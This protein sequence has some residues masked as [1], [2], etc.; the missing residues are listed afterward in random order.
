M[1][2]FDVSSTIHNQNIFQVGRLR[3]QMAKCQQVSQ[4]RPLVLCSVSWSVGLST[5]HGTTSQLRVS[6]VQLFQRDKHVLSALQ[7]DPN[8]DYPSA[9]VSVIGRLVVNV[10]ALGGRHTMAKG[11]ALMICRLMIE[12]AQLS[13]SPFGLLFLFSPPSFVG[14]GVLSLSQFINTKTDLHRQVRYRTT[15]T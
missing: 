6:V 7:G 9:V 8:S 4:G 2:A 14:S 5:P 11:Y 3:C 15:C 12:R 10:V 13:R 1:Y